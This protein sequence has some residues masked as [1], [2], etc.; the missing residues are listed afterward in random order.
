MSNEIVVFHYLGGSSD[1]YWAI[2]KEENA[3]GTHDVWYGRR[4]TRLRHVAQKGLSFAKR[5]NE[6]LKKGYERV[7]N[8]TIDVETRKVIFLDESEDSVSSIPSSLWYRLSSVVSVS[9]VQDFLDSTITALADEYAEDSLKLKDLPVYASLQQGELSGGA[10]MSE[11]PL[12]ILLLFALRRY[13]K[14][15]SGLIVS[16]DL[17]QIAD[18]S[19]N[20]LPDCFDDLSDLVMESCV[21]L[22]EHAG[23]LNDD[24]TIN[25]EAARK[26]NVQHYVSLSNI[27]QLAIAMGC[28]EAPI[29]LTVIPTDTT[30]AYF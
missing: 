7:E 20:M 6:K 30:A 9:Q 19:N 21:A 1:K 3:D 14:T 24:L 28:I 5:M 15:Q 29:D 27:R 2:R 12:A 13:F 4:G 17:V 23:Y 25:Q 16:G 26:N 10:E 22:F 18:D 11:G 8:A